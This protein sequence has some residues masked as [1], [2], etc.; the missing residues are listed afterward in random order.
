MTLDTKSL[1]AHRGWPS[2]Y[3]EN[4]LAGFCTAIDAGAGNLVLHVQF[5]RDQVPLAIHEHTSKR[6]GTKDEALFVLG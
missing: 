4:T 3:P 1:V 2:S 6:A 5:T